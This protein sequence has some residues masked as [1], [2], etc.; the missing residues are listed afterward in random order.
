MEH[1]SNWAAGRPSII[2]TDIE[3]KHHTIELT[4][5]F[6]QGH[7]WVWS[8]AYVSKPVNQFSGIR[9]EPK[10]NQPF[11]AYSLCW[12]SADNVVNPASC[13]PAS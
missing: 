2:V 4:L 13:F 12:L 3:A 10:P 7:D 5:L 9:T 11:T 1:F 6:P 8:W